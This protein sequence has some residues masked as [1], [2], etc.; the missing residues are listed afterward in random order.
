MNM[1]EP[2]QFQLINGVFTAEDASRILGAMVKGKID[3]HTLERHSHSERD[4]ARQTRSEERL[5]ELRDLSARLKELLE[6][7]VAEKR[8]L[9]I[10]GVIEISPAD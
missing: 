5:E 3:Y 2:Q 10:S 1:N 4:R 8:S 7:A 9:K 6:S